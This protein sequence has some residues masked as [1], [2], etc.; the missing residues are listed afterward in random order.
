[1]E[2][3]GDVAPTSQ[4]V[5]SWVGGWPLSERSG[6][7]QGGQG[8]QIDQPTN[9]TWSP[10]AD[11]GRQARP[12]FSQRDMKQAEPPHTALKEMMI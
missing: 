5:E 6:A 8:G 7:G 2:K 4:R 12:S 11:G 10:R 3:R 1:L 9:P